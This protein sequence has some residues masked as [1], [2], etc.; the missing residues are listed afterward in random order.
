MRQAA[1]ST[2]SWWRCASIS[3]QHHEC[4]ADTRKFRSSGETGARLSNASR[5]A[6]DTLHGAV[7]WPVIDRDEVWC[8]CTAALVALAARMRPSVRSVSV[9]QV[10]YAEEEAA[11]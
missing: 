10:R 4:S 5:L 6:V 2:S 1:C 7:L 11:V 3:T 8:V 9:L